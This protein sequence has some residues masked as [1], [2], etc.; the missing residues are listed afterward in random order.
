[1]RIRPV[2]AFIRFIAF[3]ASNFNEFLD[4]NGPYMS[5]AIAFYALFSLFPLMLALIV[6]FGLFLGLDD[7]KARL[8]EALASQVP[9]LK[10]SGDFIVSQVSDAPAVTTVLAV[11]GLLWISTGVFGSVRKSVNSIWGIKRTRPFVQ[12]R[13]MDFALM[14]GASSILFASLYT[15]TFLSILQQ[16]H[17]Y[18]FLGAR[19]TGSTLSRLITTIVPPLFSFGAFFVIYWWL[20][21]IKLRVRDVLPT[22]LAGAI[23]FE[24]AKFAFVYYL[25]LSSGPEAVYG[26][27]G[28][29]IILMAWVYVSA[30]ILL[31]G[32]Q[33]TGRYTGWLARREQMHRHDTLARNLQRVRSKTMTTAI[34]VGSASDIS[35]TVG[36]P[37]PVRRLR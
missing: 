9:V 19:T 28:A 26:Q 6:I 33:L 18:M 35:A 4:K 3:C 8:V 1:M 16:D 12:E 37:R 31:V 30:I 17:S 34:A 10:E 13:L 11:I 14:F 2:H 21:N 20:P 15:T 25:R 23:A 22:A 7:F 32:A 36:A 27:V 5:A 29:V 24:A